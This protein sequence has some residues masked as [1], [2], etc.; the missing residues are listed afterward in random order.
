MID[1][2]NAYID[3]NTGGYA[4]QILFPL[5][6]AVVGIF[7]FFKNQVISLW[8]TLARLLRRKSDDQS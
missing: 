4:F 5:I 6:S 8:R 1:T 7:L 3:P 2:A